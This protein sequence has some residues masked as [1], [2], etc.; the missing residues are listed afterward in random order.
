MCKEHFE[1]SDD[2][3]W[4]RGKNIREVPD[5]R[6]SKSLSDGGFITVGV[7][8][9]Y[10]QLGAYWTP[11]EIMQELGS[12]YRKINYNYWVYA[13]DKEI[14]NKGYKDIII[15]DVRHVNECE[16]VKNNKGV[17][18]KI[19]RLYITEIHGMQ[20]ESETALDDKPEDY[21]DITINNNGTLEDLWEAAEN[22]ADAMTTIE[23]MIKKGEVYNG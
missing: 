3:L 18:I 19:E 1:L 22:T 2:Q 16:Y 23:K 13:L 6:F 12:F 8:A 7:P 14:K 11:R 4:E 10:P 20:H 21:F 15:T 17:L 5:K 9:D